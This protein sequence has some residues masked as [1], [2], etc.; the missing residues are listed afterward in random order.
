M[1]YLIL[2]IDKLENLEMKNLS[3][4]ELQRLM[5]WITATVDANV[6]IFDEST[7][8][9]DIKQRLA[10]GKLLRNLVSEDK[11]VIVI[12]H[13]LSILDYISDSIYII[14]GEPGKFGILSNSLTA[15]D[16]INMYLNG[17]IPGQNIRIR[18]DKY[19]LK[20]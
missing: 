1:Y 5:C 3:G 18:K 8:F 7:N 20:S 19:D 2:E 11:Y 4:G 6:Y 12:D 10:V 14:Y 15:Q 9:L 16:G 17:F 13:D